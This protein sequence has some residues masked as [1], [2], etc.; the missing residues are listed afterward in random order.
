MRIALIICLIVTC[1]G[2]L[3]AGPQD[4]FFS[5][6]WLIRDFP[7]N[8]SPPG[9]FLNSE[10]NYKGLTNGD[11]IFT[12]SLARAR[13]DRPELPR[14]MPQTIGLYNAPTA[15]RYG[16]IVRRMLERGNCE[17]GVANA[18]PDKR[19]K[20][21]SDYFGGFPV[22]AQANW[23]L[24]EK[25]EFTKAFAGYGI[26]TQF[27]AVLEGDSLIGETIDMGHNWEGR[28][29]MPYYTQLRS[30]D[31]RNSSKTNRELREK[32]APLDLFWLTRSPWSEYDRYCF[33]Y[34]T[35]PGDVLVGPGS[36]KR[37]YPDNIWYWENEIREWEKNLEKGYIPYAH[38]SI[39]LEG[40]LIADPLSDT[41]DRH[42]KH[43][44]LKNLV[45]LLLSRGWKPVSSGDFLAWYSERWPCPEAPN[46]AI[47]FEDTAREP[48]GRY[49][50]PAWSNV[51]EDRETLDM[52]HIFIAETKYFRVCEH[53][54]RLS[55]F[56]ETAYELECPNLYVQK[57]AGHDPRTVKSELHGGATFADGTGW[58]GDPDQ[59]SVTAA[60]GNTLFWGNDPHRHIPAKWDYMAEKLG[61]EPLA[62]HRC[63]TLAIDGRDIQFPDEWKP[64]EYYG[65]ITNI[66]RND[67]IVSWEKY[68]TAMVDG[69][70]CRIGLKHTLAGKTHRVKL[71][72]PEGRLE[73][74]SL[75]LVFRPFFYQGW[76]ADQEYMVFAEPF[77]GDAFEYRVDNPAEVRRT[78]GFGRVGKGFR[79]YHNNPDYPELG[80]SVEV[81]LSSCAESV[82]FVDPAG[83]GQY[84]EARVALSA[85]GEFSLR[86]RRLHPL[87]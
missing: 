27:N 70:P 65:E 35:H 51:G 83:S 82:T 38:I 4:K 67:S 72:D 69:K 62:R 52:G 76:L 22:T 58:P 79:I 53:E 78:C 41:D 54:H 32:D 20:E 14:Y 16:N 85:P 66:L 19:I 1:A 31:P 45:D 8:D 84:V 74:H 33:Q 44:I 75:E 59:L 47:Y 87:D 23:E 56:M 42:V 63:Y 68:V 3:Y 34:S 86:Y 50:T 39:A 60:S 71:L 30:E 2:A 26:R 18:V 46:C 12:D 9:H 17:L 81:S 77:G 49:F 36:R 10:T 5:V 55:P 11:R 13:K 61:M 57:H 80:R 7:G 24:E 48:D 25:P 28:P 73:G 64:G 37:A 6:A 15:E 29:F 43:A 21:I 40:E